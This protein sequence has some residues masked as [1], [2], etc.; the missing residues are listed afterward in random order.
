M[1]NL[2]Y[3]ILLIFV[4]IGNGILVFLLPERIKIIKELIA[5][6]TA[7]AACAGSVVLFLSKELLTGSLRLI[8]A[9]FIDINF[10]IN[11]TPFNIFFIIILTFTSLLMTLYSLAY[12]AGK[13]YFR[14]PIS[15]YDFYAKENGDISKAPYIELL[16]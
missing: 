9:G 14:E 6:L 7:G 1:D 16:Y 5:L 4:P 10:S 12:M 2:L 13:K 11:I 15:V 3:L 8:H